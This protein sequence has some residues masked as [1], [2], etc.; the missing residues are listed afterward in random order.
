VG[1][2][3]VLPESAMFRLPKPG[4]YLD[5]RIRQVVRED[6]ITLYG[7]FDDAE[8][9]LFDLLTSV[10]GCGPKIALSLIG[11][12]GEE[13]VCGAMLAQDSRVLTRAQGVGPKLAERLILE[14]KE[15][16]AEENLHRKIARAVVSGTATN[17]VSDEL[18]QALLALGYR[19]PEAEAAAASA[20]HEANAVEEQLK[21]ALRGLAR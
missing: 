18:V 9:R 11:Q 17:G 21:I 3:V 12:V 14:L 13:A 5:L 6:S 7:F 16:I 1:Y 15:K 19:K 4:E 8:R 10:K 20:R 2:E